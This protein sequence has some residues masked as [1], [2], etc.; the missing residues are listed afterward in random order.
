M[1]LDILHLKSSLNVLYNPHMLSCTPHFTLCDSESTIEAIALK[2][3][4]TRPTRTHHFKTIDAFVGYSCVHKVM[5]KQ[6]TPLSGTAVQLW[7]SATL[8]NLPAPWEGSRMTNRIR[9]HCSCRLCYWLVRAC[10][11]NPRVFVGLGGPLCCVTLR[12]WVELDQYYLEIIPT[13]TGWDGDSSGTNC[14]AGKM[15]KTPSEVNKLC[16]RTMETPV[17]SHVNHSIT[18]LCPTIPNTHQYRSTDVII[19][20]K[21]RLRTDHV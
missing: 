10:A 14:G 8:S 9:I 17:R 21:I 20:A 13:A 7:C 11:L 15:T 1:Q 6:N 5:T 2:V 18:T 19:L 16:K 4:S 12:S 3:F